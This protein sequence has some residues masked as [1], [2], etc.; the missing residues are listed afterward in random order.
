MGQL[1]ERVTIFEPDSVD[2]DLLSIDKISVFR[3][4]CRRLAVVDNQYNSPQDCP[5]EL[6]GGMLC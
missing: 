5:G 4:D 2:E 1:S 6:S 3:D